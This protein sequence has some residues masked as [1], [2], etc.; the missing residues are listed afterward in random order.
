ML[1]QLDGIRGRE[2]V[3]VVGAANELDRIPP[4]IR[5][6][7][8]F[9]TIVNI[10]RPSRTD[11][12]VIFGQHLKP[13]E[14]DIDLEA[15]AVR[16]MG[17]TG[18]DCVAAIRKGRATARRKRSK[19]VIQDILD[20]LAGRFHAMPSDV[21]LRIAIHE[22]GHALVGNSYP[23]L[24][25]EYLRLSDDGGECRITGQAIVH[26]SATLHRDRTV[27]LAGRMAEILVLGAPSSGAGGDSGSHLA[28][29][30]KLAANEV[31]AYGLGQNGALWLGSSGSDALMREIMNDN[32]SEVAGLI[33]AAETEAQSR[34][35]PLLP[36]I[37][38]MARAVL[39]TGVLTGDR[40]SELLSQDQTQD[41]AQ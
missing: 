21:L 36:S 37:A 15:C 38:E 18:A 29:A 8:R 12:V 9:D 31:G 33:T 17:R 6:S 22:C 35:Q 7:R 41:A 16:A 27:L 34:L 1:E 3:I 13:G 11:L 19:M 28:K 26:T 10:P 39:D 23:E 24:T 4:A 14:S 20:E 30:A 32:L 2:G 40:L 25:V 5:R